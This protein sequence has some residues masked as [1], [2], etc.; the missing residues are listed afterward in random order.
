[1]PPYQ[2]P[3]FL[4]LCTILLAHQCAPTQGP[5]SSALNMLLHWRLRPLVYLCLFSQVPVKGIN[6]G[7]ETI[8]QWLFRE[9]T[10]NLLLDVE[11]GLSSLHVAT[12]GQKN[13]S[14]LGETFLSPGR[15][16]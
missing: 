12:G 13:G 8:F 14:H 11:A 9:A 3:E 16:M 4:H 6:I 1:M 2:G 10:E 5:E 7:V 15:G